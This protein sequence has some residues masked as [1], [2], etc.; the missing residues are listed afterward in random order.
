MEYIQKEKNLAASD[1]IV[2]SGLEPLI[3]YGILVGTVLKVSDKPSELF[4][5]ADVQPAADFTSL[6]VVAIIHTI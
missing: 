1:L 6:R 5:Y 3:P 2:T 4:L